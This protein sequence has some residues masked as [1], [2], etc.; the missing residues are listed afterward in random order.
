MNEFCQPIIFCSFF[1]LR[2]D[3]SPAILYCM[4]V[5]LSWTLFG[6]FYLQYF[7]RNGLPLTYL[8]VYFRMNTLQNNTSS[9]TCRAGE[10]WKSIK[11]ELDLQFYKLTR[12]YMY[13]QYFTKYSQD[14]HPV[15]QS[16]SQSVSQS[17]NPSDRQWAVSLSVS[18][19]S[20]HTNDSHNAPGSETTLQYSRFTR[21]R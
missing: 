10:F 9:W 2:A 3:F 12:K 1:V 5:R 11:C 7:C 13:I 19:R 8:S 17:V 21:A 4:F 6:Q 16:V 20:Q 14:S 18:Q 15:R